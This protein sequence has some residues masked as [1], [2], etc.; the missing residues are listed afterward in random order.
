MTNKNRVTKDPIE[1]LKRDS[2][3]YFI[4]PYDL[5]KRLDEL[6]TYLRLSK[7]GLRVTV[8]DVDHEWGLCEGSP[9]ITHVLEGSGVTL[10]LYVANAE[11]AADINTQKQLH[12]LFASLVEVWGREYR[13]HGALNYQASDAEEMLQNALLPMSNAHDILKFSIVYIDL[14]NFK[15]LNDQSSHTEGDRAI[16]CVYAEMHKLCKKLGGLAFIAGGDEFLLLLPCDKPMDVSSHLWELRNQVHAL[17]FG[18]KKKLRIGMTA[19]VVTRSL[20]EVSKGLNSIKDICEELTKSGIDKKE[21]RRGTI[22]FER[23]TEDDL[24][25]YPADMNDYFKLGICFS[26]SRQKLENCFDD[27]RL[28]LISRQVQNLTDNPPNPR[29]VKQAVDDVLKWFGA[30]VTYECDELSLFKRSRDSSEIS[31][32]SIC[33]AILHALSKS[34]VIYKWAGIT[35][36]TIGVSWSTA[37]GTCQV[38]FKDNA[39]WG[40]VKGVMANTLSFGKLVAKGQ[41][42]RIEGIAVG[43]QIGFDEIP[44]TPTGRTLPDGFLIDH[45]RVDVRPRTGGGLPDFWQA[46]LAQIVSALDKANKPTKII[47]W[48]ENLEST[49]IYKRLTVPKLWTN[50][51]IA[52]LTGLTTDRVRQL[53]S[54]LKDKIIAVKTAPDLLINL[55]D[56]YKIFDG[57]TANG[58]QTTTN[59]EYSLKRPMIEATPLDQSEGIVCTTARKAYPLIVDTLRK[60][61]N[62]RSA[63]DDSGQEQRE[64]IAFK[65]KLTAPQEDKIPN[66]LQNQVD[67]LDQ[68]AKS[69]LLSPDGVIRK[70]IEDDNQISAYCNHLLKYI[71]QG[72]APRSTRRA[73]LIVP[74]TPDDNGGPRPLGLIS[75][76]STPRFTPNVVYLDFVFVWRTVE[77]FIGLPYSLYGSISLAEQLTQRL[78]DASASTDVQI[79]ELNYIALSLHIGSDEFHTRVAK[80]IVDMASD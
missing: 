71:N 29:K 23:S 1:K 52:N 72:P 9:S 39:V 7:I 32:S 19:G 26:K 43:V 25:S 67:D 28:N 70:T 18:G 27:E 74:H 45:V 62:V 49:E 44:R 68:Y 63:T 41:L 50:D 78:S 48:G 2:S 5:E 57:S 79:G 37:S 46:A 11:Q 42:N 55:Y 30:K 21:K 10:A 35:D 36:K 31:Q 58:R 4:S 73:C 13:K 60:T 15:N 61:P 75:V 3:S 53:V 14:D 76:W 66:Y 77:A 54:K 47:I 59:E 38:T 56:S 16:R 80:Q 12:Q 69:V 20:D 51:E 34:A 8:T 64:L 65:L 40:D 6:A 22:S 24:E 33:V 17:S